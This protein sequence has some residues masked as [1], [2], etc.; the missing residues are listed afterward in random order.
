[1]LIVNMV[2]LGVLHWTL[3]PA[4]LRDVQSAV[5]RYF[6]AVYAKWMSTHEKFVNKHFLGMKREKEAPHSVGYAA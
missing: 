6:A 4:H 5:F 3:A 2:N 1:M